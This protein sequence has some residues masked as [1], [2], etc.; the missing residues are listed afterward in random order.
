MTRPEKPTPDF[1][2][3]PHR[4]GQWAKKVKGKLL[5]YG[6][7]SDP[8]GALARYQ[9]TDTQGQPGVN[10]RCRNNQRYQNSLS[11][12]SPG[13]PEK[14]SRYIPTLPAVGPRRYGALPV[15]LALGE[16]LKLPWTS[17]LTNG[18]TSWPAGNRGQR[19]GL[20]RSLSGQPVL[21]EQREPPQDGRTHPAELGRLRRNLCQNHRCLWSQSACDRSAPHRF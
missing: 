5:Y 18:M 17:G 1:P 11:R 16:T 2:L 10:P 4:N 15:S 20:D 13:S 8:Q 7:W 6:P 19:G 9:N 3:F 21:G 14:T 12:S